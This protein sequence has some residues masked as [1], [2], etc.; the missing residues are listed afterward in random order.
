MIAIPQGWALGAAEEAV[1][2]RLVRL[3]QERFAERLFARDDALWGSD[4]A[5]R[6]VAANRLGWLASPVTM[7]E[8]IPALVQFAGEVR[9]DGIERAVLLGMG[10]SSLAPEVLA[11]TFG[12]ARGAL[13]VSVLDSTSPAAV[14]EIAAT[15]DPASTLYI[16]SS[17]SGTTLEVTSFERRPLPALRVRSS[18]RYRWQQTPCI[19]SAARAQNVLVNVRLVPLPRSRHIAPPED[20][21][22]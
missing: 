16:V 17:K 12:V 1:R 2:G 15:H 20:R 14:R 19:R 4:P 10:G 3:G 18:D 7:R 5:H 6:K 8:Q 9:R 11:R 22:W 21:Q 13:G